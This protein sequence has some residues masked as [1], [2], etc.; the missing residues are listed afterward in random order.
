[1]TTI[2]QTKLQELIGKYK[3]D[4]ETNIPN[5]LYKWKAVKCFQDNWNID[6]GDFASMLK[7]SLAKTENLLIAPSFYPKLMI[8]KYVDLYPEDVRSLFG[9]LYS[10]EFD[11][12]ERIASFKSGIEDIHKKWDNIGDKNHYQNENIISTYLWLRYPDKYYI[13]K[14]TL[15]SNLCNKLGIDVRFRGLGA[16][17]VIQAYKIYDTVSEALAQD[18][19]YVAL[20]NTWLIGD[21][22][23]DKYCKTATIDFAY[24]V[25]KYMEDARV[26][27]ATSLPYKTWDDAIVRVLG[28]NDTPMKAT[29]IA[30]IVRRKGFYYT[31]GKTPELSINRNMSENTSGL[32]KSEGRGY[33]SLSNYGKSKY[34]S[35]ISGKYSMVNT[36]YQQP[37]QEDTI[38]I[39][40]EN[41]K[42]EYDNSYDSTKFLSEVFMSEDDYNKL[43]SQL[44]LKKNIILQ[45]APGV[46][47]TFSAKRLAYSIMGK[48][49]D[50]RICLVQFHQNYS[51]EDFVEGYKPVEEGFKLCK[52][53]FYN[54]C[55]QAKNNPNDDYFFIIDEINRGN[56]SKIFGELLMLIEKG[57]RGEKMT[58]AYSGEKFH[59]PENLH[60]IGMMN[61]ADRSLAMIDYALRRRFSFFTLKPGFE[62]DGF[63]Q[64]QKELNN[65][66]YDNLVAKIIDLNREIVK[67]DSLGAGFEIGHSYL[68]FKAANEVNDEWLY[69]V[70]HHDIIPTLQEYWF[71][72]ADAVKRWTENLTNILND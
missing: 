38:P 66:T 23:A 11:L 8:E 29:E 7:N 60:I 67:D 5:E 17:A 71:D 4:F 51:Y 39:V 70:V 48:K 54:F 32:Y 3:A 55:T 56:L 9:L 35:I 10:E 40:A 58:L 22:Y 14:P 20:L 33:Y 24:Y 1:M 72:N 46:G 2:D 68:C 45:G 36:D 26:S 18:E 47:K 65:A 21:C 42:T 37:K 43:R 62:S 30:G 50:C 15:A 64:R 31:T 57:Y 27:I 13:Y 59:V 12:S 28:D 19:E 34:L 44:L 52:G 61:T 25:S 41:T 49:D 16:E 53:V 69:A 63:I 6:A